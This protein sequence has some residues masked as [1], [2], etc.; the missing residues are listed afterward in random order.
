[1]KTEARTLAWLQIAVPRHVSCRVRI[2][3][4]KRGVPGTG[5]AI[6]CKLPIQAPAIDG[7]GSVIGDGNLTHQAGAPIV[8]HFVSAPCSCVLVS[9]HQAG[10]QQPGRNRV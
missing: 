6:I 8:N 5:N 2:A 9:N 4:G 1:M 7:G 3:S 10:S